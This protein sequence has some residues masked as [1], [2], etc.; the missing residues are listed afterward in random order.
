MAKRA[1]RVLRGN[2]EIGFSWRRSR[3]VHLL[4]QSRE[5][6]PMFTH[7]RLHERPFP[8]EM[9][10]G[11]AITEETPLTPC[12]RSCRRRAFGWSR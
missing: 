12:L 8:G 9:S 1:F 11:A 10:V 6:H 3:S 2:E 5:R 4:A 7:A